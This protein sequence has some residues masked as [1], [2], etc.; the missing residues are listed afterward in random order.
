MTVLTTMMIVVI[1][2][3]MYAHIYIY[4]LYYN[5]CIYNATCNILD[6]E[7]AGNLFLLVVGL[8]EHLQVLLLP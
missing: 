6:L 8:C 4:A 5:I 7:V 3:H 2:M 1:M